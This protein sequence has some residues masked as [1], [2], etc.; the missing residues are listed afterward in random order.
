M[1]MSY[2]KVAQAKDRL[3]IG[4][5]QSTKAMKSGDVSLIV[6]A[7]DIDANLKVDIINLAD[8]M[9]IPYEMVESKKQL[10]KACGI[11]VG[12]ALVAVKQ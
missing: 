5:K 9:N 11:E 12:T 2:E 4:I 1:K 7:L 8:E 6:V 3:L 10:G